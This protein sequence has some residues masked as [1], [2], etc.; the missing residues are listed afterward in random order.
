MNFGLA[1]LTGTGRIVKDRRAHKR[2]ICRIPYI[3]VVDGESHDIEEEEEASYA[4]VSP[5]GRFKGE[6]R[7]KP[8]TFTAAQ[9]GESRGLPKLLSY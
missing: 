2:H 8:K 4:G 3:L 9:Y 6:G 1:G 7:I 5:V